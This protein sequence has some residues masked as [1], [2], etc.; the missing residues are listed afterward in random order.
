MKDYRILTNWTITTNLLI[1]IG[2]GH[3]IG[4]LG[5]IEILLLPTRLEEGITFSIHASY[6]ERLG[7]A[8]LLSLFGQ[9]LM[10]SSYLM[11]TAFYKFLIKLYGIVIL[12]VGFIYLTYDF[13]SNTAATLGLITGIP[14]MILSTLLMIKLLRH[15][16]TW[17]AGG[18]EGK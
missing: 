11:S 16:I 18:A 6:D 8:A 9:L 13:T 2:A 17:K 5:L 1:V 4:V 15:L 12:W 10:I 7:A 14:F 3:G